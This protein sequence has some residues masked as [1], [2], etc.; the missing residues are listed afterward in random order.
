[1]SRRPH[2]YFG[3]LNRLEEAGMAGAAQA[4]GRAPKMTPQQEA[5]ILWEAFRAAARSATKAR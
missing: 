4:H 2:P 1:L 3:R 5:G